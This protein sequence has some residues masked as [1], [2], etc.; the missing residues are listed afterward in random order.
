MIFSVH[1]QINK[2]YCM[3]FNYDVPII[4]LQ[5]SHMLKI[6]AIKKDTEN[7]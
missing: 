4:A 5:T 3:Y 1:S 2:V 6:M 7:M